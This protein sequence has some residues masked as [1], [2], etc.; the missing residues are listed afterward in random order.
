MDPGISF[1]YTVTEAM[2]SS[3]FDS[4]GTTMYQGTFASTV[5]RVRGGARA[6]TGPA[7][8]VALARRRHR[9]RQT[10]P[11]KRGRS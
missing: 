10:H 5:P 2:T 7:E 8:L 1:G 3:T 9:A 11:G 4:E 6:P